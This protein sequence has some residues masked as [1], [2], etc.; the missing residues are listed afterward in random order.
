MQSW[1]EGLETGVAQVDAEH[2]LQVSLI[3]ALE[4]LLGRGDDPAL[5]ERTA[6]QL[7]DFTSVHCL[8]EELVMRLHAYPQLDAHLLEHGRLMERVRDLREQV[9]DGAR[10]EASGAI[11][12]LRTWLVEHVRSMDQ[13][14]AR[15]CRETGAA[16]PPGGEAAQADDAGSAKGPSGSG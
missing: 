13:A 4:A 14:F 1:H 9:V 15:W 8:S 6:G 7:V 12:G 5:A 16:E 3:N 11:A 10:A 2:R